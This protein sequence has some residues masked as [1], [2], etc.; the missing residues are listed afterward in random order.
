MRE[1]LTEGAVPRYAFFVV[2]G[3]MMMYILEDNARRHWPTGSLW[4]L[5]SGA[6]VLL[7]VYGMYYR[8]KKEKS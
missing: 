4:G 1:W 8:S 2:W 7:I 6:V 3:I 5:G